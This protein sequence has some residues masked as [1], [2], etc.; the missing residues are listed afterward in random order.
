MRTMF[1]SIS[2]TA[3]PAGAD[4]YAG[5]DDGNWPDAAGIAAFHPG[6]TVV[7]ITV[8]PADEIGDVLDVETGDATPTD[9]PRWV[10]NR[11]DLGAD[12]SVYCTMSSWL[13]CKNAFAVY[14][15]AE[16]HWWVAHWT[17]SL[18]APPTG[19]VALQWGHG[20][21]YDKSS[22]VDYWPGIDPAPVPP[23]PPSPNPQPTP[24]VTGEPV[25]AVEINVEVKQGHGWASLPVPAGSV[26]SVVIL[27]T[28][29]QDTASYAD[30]PTSWAIA[31]EAGSTSP[32]GVVVLEGG[33][34]G[35]YGVV[36]WVLG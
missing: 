16:P 19:A 7:R 27:A 35:T 8:N 5:Y 36:L 17:T 23:S 24:T 30:V 20:S 25:H 28:N 32:N 31:S 33:A 15:I 18:A 3:L 10:H 22:V 2:V 34:D 4:L 1:D 14:G 29:P 6:K 11:R 12:P 13:A 26:V 21:G 9:A